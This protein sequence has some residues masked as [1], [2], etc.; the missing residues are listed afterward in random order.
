MGRMPQLPTSIASVPKYIVIP[1]EDSAQW[2]PY[3]DVG[4]S[5]ISAQ[6]ARTRAVALQTLELC[7]ISSDILI[8]FYNPTPPRK[9][10]GVMN[11]GSRNNSIPG[12]MGNSD[13]RNLGVLWHR[14]E[15]WKKKLPRELEPQQ[16]CLPQVLLMNMFHQLLYIHLFRPFLQSTSDTLL[17]LSLDPR[18]IC[19]EASSKISKYVRFYKREYGL[20]QICNIAAYMIHSACTIH[21]LNLPERT[22]KRDIVQGLR[23]LEDMADG[24]L[25]ARRALVIM[26]ILSKRWKIDLP[27]EAVVILARAAKGRAEEF[28]LQEVPDEDYESSYL[29]YR[30]S[31]ASAMSPMSVLSD[32]K[33]PSPGEMLPEQSLFMKESQGTT[34]GRVG[35]ISSSA[36]SPCSSSCGS[37]GRTPSTAPRKANLPQQQHPVHSQEQLSQ[38]TSGLRYPT[39]VSAASSPGS[40]TSLPFPHQAQQPYHQAQNTR[41]YIDRAS[42]LGIRTSPLSTP[43][44][45]HPPQSTADSTSRMSRDTSNHGQ[46]QTYFDSPH[47]PSGM[48]SP[49][50]FYSDTGIPIGFGDRSGDLNGGGLGQS[51]CIRDHELVAQGFLV[52]G[53]WLSSS[54]LGGPARG[55]LSNHP[56]GDRESGEAVPNEGWNIYTDYM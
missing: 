43:P 38:T 23:S 42:P 20:R 36:H 8:Q 53:E 11:L 55:L 47:P 7:E 24:W 48:T 22:A 32:S 40:Y 29:D 34:A 3:T 27:D 15:D 5:V 28:G 56:G 17:T 18:K 37:P 12:A 1:A 54:G 21:L 13:I 4:K 25:C 31:S 10:S 6:P 2:Y 51:W 44:S 14:L 19:V 30:G 26:R 49:S 35:E 46:A 52:Q 9:F 33:A 45:S 50:T 39:D 16:G 41:Q